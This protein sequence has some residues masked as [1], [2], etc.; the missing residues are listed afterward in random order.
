MIFIALFVELID[1]V[2]DDFACLIRLTL[3]VIAKQLWLS[4]REQQLGSDLSLADFLLRV[5]EEEAF[6]DE[7]LL[8][9]LQLFA[10][11]GFFGDDVIE[12]VEETIQQ[13]VDCVLASDLVGSFPDDGDDF[14][15]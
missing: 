7:F 12:D 9:I 14:Q 5:V 6:G 15:G 10:D 4:G 11:L 8:E 1:D 13:F 2:H 3:D